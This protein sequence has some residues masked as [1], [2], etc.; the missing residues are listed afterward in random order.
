MKKRMGLKVSLSAGMMA[1][2]A[3]GVMA[4]NAEIHVN[5]R[6][7]G[8]PVSPLLYGIF[9][10]EINHAGDG[11]LY[12][13]LVRNRS[14][15]DAATPEG[16]KLASA[17]SGATLALDKSRPL[18]AQNL[19]AFRV[20]MPS[21]SSQS[22]IVLMNEGFWGMN[23]EKGKAYRFTVFARMDAANSAP[24]HIHLRENR[25]QGSIAES[26]ITTIGADWK[27][28]T[29][30]LKPRISTV[31]H[32]ALSWAGGGSVWLDSISLFPTQTFKN[33][34][35]G[36]R[37]DLAQRLVEMRPAFVRFPGGCFVEGGRMQNAFKWKQT[38][39][40][41]HTRPG[42]LNDV[43]NYRSTDGLGYHEYLQLC[44]DV[45][46]EPMFVVNCGMAHLDRIP[47]N[48]LDA[49]IQ[50][51]LDAVEYANG[52]TATKW[53][54]LRAK[55][56]HPK[57]FNLRLLEIGN[58]NGWGDTLPAYEERYARFHDALRAKYPNVTLIANV[59]IK[60]RQP[61]VLDDHFYQ[62]ADW[63]VAN[64]GMYDKRDRRLPKIYVGEYAVTQ[65]A[66]LGNLKAALGEAVWMMGMERNS[67]AVTMAS[68]APLFVNVNDRKWNPDAIGFD[69]ARSYVTPSYHVQQLFAVHRPDITLPTTA[70][71]SAP[72]LPVPTGAVG[73]GTWRTQSEYRNL[74]VEADG[75][76][77]YTDNLA[78]GVA[79]WRTVRGKWHADNGVLR[80]DDA[81]AE[82]V[83]GVVGDPNWQNYTLTLQARKLSGAEG[84]LIMFRA[85][86]DQNWYW[87][88]IGGWNNTLHAVEK[89]TNGSKSLVTAQTPGSVETGRWYDIK[90]I[91][92]GNRL[93]CFLDGKRIH[94]V[95]EKALTPLHAIGGYDKRKGEYIVKVVNYGATP[96]D[97][98]VFLEGT[99]AKWS[100]SITTLSGRPDAENSLQNPNN[101][102]PKQTEAS[103]EGGKLRRTFPPYSLTI[104]RLK[105]QGKRI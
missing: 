85:R 93:Q 63:F 31:G 51:A 60:N 77:L 88:N 43:W 4:Q 72:A 62:S 36:L 52:S 83:R 69:A 7:A 65:G 78:S 14:F 30:T 33:R 1:I 84:F 98:T 18:N 48:E 22:P 59:P 100:Q 41:I 49:W 87:W 19:T 8:I 57:P 42:H 32:L 73:V 81:A 26:T 55:N 75:R 76:T 28:Y 39:G 61:D 3:V 99:E 12:A 80:Q 44:E 50:D 27:Q 82:D 23:F 101:V 91:V 89:M 6:A 64:A 53:G 79:G 103:S 86:N 17:S 9:F 29:V 58:E 102:A 10:E 105:P 40:E 56:G 34:P 13:E 46:A 20:D 45:G 66:G 15:E 16:W 96:Q 24:L 47:M 21:R 97:T 5:T 35:N 70:Q 37:R 74:K 25:T 38:L 2:C 94:E 90:I 67:D 68:Y 11:G 104:L 95:E 71:S 54:A 92:E